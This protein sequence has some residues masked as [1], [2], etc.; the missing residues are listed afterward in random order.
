M[1]R[2]KG[3]K[4]KKPRAARKDKPV[5]PVEGWRWLGKADEAYQMVVELVKTYYAKEL[6]IGDVRPM[7]RTPGKP[8]EWGCRLGSVPGHLRQVQVE[9]QTN[10]VVL[11]DRDWWEKAD[12]RERQGRLHA[13]LARA[14]KEKPVMVSESALRAHGAYTGEIRDVVEA[15]AKQLE[16]ELGEAKAAFPIASGADE[17]PVDV[18]AMGP[19][20]ECTGSTPES[21]AVLVREPSREELVDAE[22]SGQPGDYDADGALKPLAEREEERA[23]RAMAEAALPAEEPLGLLDGEEGVPVEA[24]VEEFAEAV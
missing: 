22:V 13:L 20:G 16:L 21:G 6:S 19:P 14:A 5:Y 9:G 3:S 1:G 17:V 11:V 12:V 4:N 8:V 7:L 15:G 10:R 2:P 23:A 18:G 24:G